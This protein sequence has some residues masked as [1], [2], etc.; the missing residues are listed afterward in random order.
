[1]TDYLERLNYWSVLCRTN[2]QVTQC[3]DSL[4]HDNVPTHKSLVA[5]QALCNCESVQLNHPAYSPDLVPSDY[6]IIRNLKYHLRGTWFLD[7]ESLTIANKDLSPI[8]KFR[9]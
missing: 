5:Q 4:F 2:I 8:R 3:H 6:F 7:D 9:A 1:M